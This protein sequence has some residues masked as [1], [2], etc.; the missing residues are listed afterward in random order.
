VQTREFL[1]QL[2]QELFKLKKYNKISHIL[3]H[4]LL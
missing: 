3:L 4:R 1:P 2:L